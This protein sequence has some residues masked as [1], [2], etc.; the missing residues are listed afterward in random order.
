M[1]NIVL[2]IGGGLIVITLIFGLRELIASAI[3]KGLEEYDYRKEK[4]K[5]FQKTMDEVGWAMKN[6]DNKKKKG[7]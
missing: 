4:G 7:K 1:D 2:A 3:V 5:E 6:D